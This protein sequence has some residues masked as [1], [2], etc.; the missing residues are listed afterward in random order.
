[1]STIHFL[2]VKNGDCSI[3]EHDSGN[4]SIIDICNARLTSEASTDMAVFSEAAAKEGVRGNF[5]QKKHPENPI[6]YLKQKIKPKHIFRYIQTHPDMDHMD[7][8][9]DLAQQYKILNFWD[10]TNNK[11]Q[12]FNS[13][14]ESPNSGDIINNKQQKKD[15]SNE[16]R[17]EDWAY[18]QK[19]RSSKEKT[20]V[21]HLYSGNIGRYFNDC[22]EKICDG[23][24]ILSPTI[25]LVKEAN[26]KKDYNDASYVLLF[27]EKGKRVVFGGD[28]GKR[29]WDHILKNHSDQLKNI[30]LLIAPH[31]GRCSG[32]NEEYLDVLK[33][34]L[35]LFGNA[36][37][38]D[39]DYD[40]Y[41][42]RGLEI[43]TNNQAGNI[44]VYIKERGLYIF[45]ENKSYAQKKGILTS[46]KDEK[47]F[48][49]KVI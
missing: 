25:D 12:E 26:E 29:T 43:I 5:N 10:T 28:S 14:K 30:D 46:S 31:H 21:L 9:S 34:K 36:K 22:D 37:A 24:S 2:N 15:S 32:G 33:P 18:Y 45:V 17:K 6:D 44:I 1:M 11:Q 16:Y 41:Y 49:I 47:L 7:G 48:C 13:G 35:T 42:N 20:K 3:I 4:V 8:L 23:I 19:I 38:K 27:Q 39:L 40:S